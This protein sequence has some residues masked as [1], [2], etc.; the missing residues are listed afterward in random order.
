[1][2]SSPPLLL[3][4]L[5]WFCAVCQAQRQQAVN[6]FEATTWTVDDAP[7][8]EV[9]ADIFVMEQGTL[10]VD[11]GVHVNFTGPFSIF[12]RGSVVL[13]GDAEN[14][15]LVSNGFK[16]FVLMEEVVQATLTAK[17][18]I[19]ENNS[20]GA[21]MREWPSD[22]ILPT[23]QVHNCI[24][25]D[26]E[27]AIRSFDVELSNSVIT[28]GRIGA[29]LHRSILLNA[30]IQD[31]REICL[32]AGT[33]SRVTDSTIQNCGTMG[34]QIHG[35]ARNTRVS[36]AAE[37]VAAVIVE[38]EDRF[39]SAEVHDCVIQQISD[40][41]L[42]Y[43]ERTVN[44]I[45]HDSPNAIGAL[46]DQGLISR[47]IIVGNRI[48]VSSGA[49]VGDTAGGTIEDSYVCGN[50]QSQFDAMNYFGTSNATRVYFGNTVAASNQDRLDQFFH[51]LP[52]LFSAR[53]SLNYDVADFTVQN[54]DTTL[55]VEANAF[56]VCGLVG[57]SPPPQPTTPT[58]PAP[59]PPSDSRPTKKEAPLAAKC[60]SVASTAGRGGAAG[61]SK[62]CLRRDGG[63]KR[64]FIRGM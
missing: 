23:I 13:N 52:F 47:S 35:T 11:P 51:A 40:V 38:W 43:I 46:L 59:T 55:L 49:L 18:T 54:L 20:A 8:V 50:S 25:T 34:L 6:I 21:I 4:I 29:S 58:T 39:E 63:K 30:T 44:T 19:F 2:Q 37:G 10:T 1:M 9:V 61:Q 26:N 32:F 36:N 41:G 56:Q 17:H 24:F 7:I 22:S 57:P 62:G 42:K 45:V 33:D 3:L 53:G 14:P 5:G 16:A 64:R 15:I 60:G 12:V 27:Y 48:G 31:S 28:G